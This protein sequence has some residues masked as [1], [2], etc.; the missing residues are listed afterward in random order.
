MAI[1]LPPDLE[2]ALDVVA[3]RRG[4][5][6]DSFV[7]NLVRRELSTSAEAEPAP[8]GSLAEFLEGYAGVFDSREFIP[9]G[10]GMSE[11]T[12][13][14]FTDVLVEKRAQGRL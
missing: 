5:T 4:T 7:E 10:A 11:N 1:Q 9:G 8:P 14:Q 2:E 12:G 6:P 13:E 3:R